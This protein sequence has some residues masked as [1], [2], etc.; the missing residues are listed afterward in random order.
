MKK[1]KFEQMAVIKEER[2]VSVVSDN[3]F[4]VDDYQL[5][6]AGNNFACAVG[7][8]AVWLALKNNNIKL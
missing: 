6:K 3:F 4:Q 8:I 1:M 2:I 5:P 7:I